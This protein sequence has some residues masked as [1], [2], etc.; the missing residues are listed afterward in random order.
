MLGA[1]LVVERLE[2][3]TVVWVGVVAMSSAERVMAVATLS[4]TLAM[5][6]LVIEV[7]DS[8]AE[9][10]SV[11]AITVAVMFRL[12]GFSRLVKVLPK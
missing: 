8:A 12:A 4:A 6:L 9:V 2:T 5:D 1:T 7:G 3:E 11:K 10:S